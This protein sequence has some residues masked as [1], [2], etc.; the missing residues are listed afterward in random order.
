MIAVKQRLHEFELMGYQRGHPTAQS[1]AKAVLDFAKDVVDPTKIETKPRDDDDVAADVNGSGG[2]EAGGGKADAPAT[3][4]RTEDIKKGWEADD[5]EEEDDEEYGLKRDA[6]GNDDDDELGGTV[7]DAHAA[8]SGLFDDADDVVALGGD[9]DAGKRGPPSSHSNFHLSRVRAISL[10]FEE[11]WAQVFASGEGEE[12]L[13][14]NPSHQSGVANL[15]S[16][17]LSTAG[18]HA[19]ATNWQAR[20]CLVSHCVPTFWVFV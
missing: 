9:A 1:L 11:R 7:V 13:L 10:P 17:V 8:A 20:S 6:R 16:E 5:G 2:C 14:A 15:I 4:T 12:Y 19:S 3:D 18:A